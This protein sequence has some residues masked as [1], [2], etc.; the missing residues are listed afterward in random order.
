[1]PNVRVAAMFAV[2][3]AG[4]S[5]CARRSPPN[6][7]EH[8]IA[9][10]ARNAVA[11]QKVYFG[12]FYEDYVL[13][14]VFRDQK[15]GTY[16]DVGANHPNLDNVTN[17][18]Y[19]RGWHGI[20]VEPHPRAFAALSQARPRDVNLNVGIAD[21]AGTM[22]YYDGGGW[23]GL[24][25]F[26]REIALGH[27]AAGW[28]FREIPVPVLTL[29]DVLREHP[30]GEIKFMNV[31]VEGFE[32]RVLEGID[33]GEH[34]PIVI[35]VEATVPKSD[36]DTTSQWEPPLRKAGYLFALFDGLNRYYLHPSR[37]DL[38]QR[39]AEIGF[40]VTMD[41]IKRGIKLDSWQRQ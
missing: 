40:C 26:D 25:T 16:I 10:P 14:Y 29:N 31:D 36:A 8:S 4:V 23:G 30:L 9:C 21:T 32:R 28:K 5:A 15:N 35:M 24:S 41:K 34:H 12:Q 7:G 1:M 27:E 17:Y 39:F 6:E 19:V 2:L 18:F 33:L 11:S 3:L 37:R 13:A 20:N 22:T 38:L